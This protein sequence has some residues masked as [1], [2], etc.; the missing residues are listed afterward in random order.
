MSQYVL[1]RM[2]GPCLNDALRECALH[3]AAVRAQHAGVMDAQACGK[4]NHFLISSDWNSIKRVLSQGGCPG[5]RLE[6]VGSVNRVPDPAAGG[7]SYFAGQRVDNP[8]FEPAIAKQRPR[9]LN[10]TKTHSPDSNSSPISR[11]RDF[12]MSFCRNGKP[13]REDAE[14]GNVRCTARLHAVQG[15]KRAQGARECGA[16]LHAAFRTRPPLVRSLMFDA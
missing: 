11:L 16:R 6:R 4:R 14:R 1:F 5:P 7:A 8:T 13:C 15:G 9:L 2:R 3:Q 12:L 10:R